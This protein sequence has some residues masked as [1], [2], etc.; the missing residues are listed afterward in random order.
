[1]PDLVGREAILKVHAIKV[2]LDPAVDFKTI[3][4]QTTYFSGADLANL[5]NEAA[6]LAARLN[7]ETVGMVELQE[8]IERVMAG[9][10]RK[11][12]KVSDKERKIVAHHEAG[13]ALVALMTP[14][15]D[16]VHKV[17][18]IPRGLAGGYTVT[19]PE[20][21][22]TLHS[23]T[24]FL[25]EIPVL[26]G[27]RVAEEL[28]FGDITTG[29]HNDLQKAT[30][31]AREMVCR[32]G[33]SKKL[34]PVV[35]G[36]EGGGMVFLGRDLMDEKNYS[37]E[38]AQAIDSEIKR[39]IEE[40]YELS[41]K[42]LTENRDKLEALASLLLEKETLDAEEIKKVTGLQVA[43]APDGGIVAPTLD[44]GGKPVA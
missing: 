34:G 13:H 36:K 38:T 1:M 28:I 5:V 20:E 8:S 27:G 33:M 16:P 9:P 14:G 12:K 21:D 7:K 3:A 18:I 31:I 32:F 19:L 43:A 37:E 26:M 30:H 39:I 41:K 22:R 6:L 25:A 2:K 17:T 44:L 35:F 42:I 24:F 15:A 10:Q 40:G 4:K 11:S 23:R 29:A